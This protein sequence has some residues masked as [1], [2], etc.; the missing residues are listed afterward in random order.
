MTDKKDNELELLF[1][2]GRPFSPIYSCMM[3]NRR[4]LYLKGVFRQHR[5]AVPVI[6]VGNLVMGGT[7]K[8]P[9]VQYI[10][11][12]LLKNNRKPG[13]LSR[14]YKGSARS[15]VNVVS[16]GREILLGADE[17]GD[18]PRLLAETLPGIPVITGKKRYPAGCYALKNLAVDTLILDDGFQHLAVKRDVDLVL[19]SA[20]KLLGTGRVLPGGELREPLSALNRADGFVI[21]GAEPQFASQVKDFV[22]FLENKFPDIPVFSGKYRPT[23]ILRADHNK[24]DSMPIS[25]IM[26]QPLFGFCGIAQPESLESTLKELQ[27]NQVGFQPFPDHYIYSQNDL[28]LLIEKAKAS[29]ATGLITT[30]KDFVKL[31]NTIVHDFPLL[32]LSIQLEMDDAFDEF[33]FTN[34]K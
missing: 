27:I 30:A 15:S 13:I 23:E 4:N 3:A 7:G 17:A 20:R 34:L 10:A 19:F 31:K 16:N 24:I 29:G 26:E 22:V 33:I 11:R 1:K 6:S 9:L 5:L 2:L 28:L 18:E 32:A 12:L 14:G 21:T 25:K 8:T